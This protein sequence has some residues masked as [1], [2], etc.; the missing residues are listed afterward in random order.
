[1]TCFRLR[2]RDLHRACLPAVAVL[3][4][5]LPGLLLPG[6][7]AHAGEFAILA[8]P[9]RIEAQARPGETWRNIVELTNVARSDTPLT[10]KTAD[11]TLDASGNAQFDDALADGSC[12][13]WAAIEAR[14]FNLGAGRKR[15]F[16]FEVDV[17]ADAPQGECRFA[18]M[19][20]GA[21]QAAPGDVPVPVSGRLGI[22]VYLAIGDAA[23]YLAVAGH[24][25]AMVQ[26]Q[27]LP[28][29]EISNTG[30]AHGRLDGYLNGTDAEGRRIALAPSSL[31]ILAGETRAII[32]SPVQDDS[33]TPVPAIHYPLTLKGRLDAG[34]QRV[35]ID[36]VVRP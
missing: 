36:F 15:R 22:I 14:E 25:V 19:F 13:P 33:G 30:D 23:P 18:L 8:S 10:V 21:P 16:R 4:V 24:H 34:R 20:E 5:L 1:M 35:D 28:V 29:L 2:V 26:G 6:T 11:W 12:R 7:N 32:L 31:P 3:G 9:P 17:P 27:R